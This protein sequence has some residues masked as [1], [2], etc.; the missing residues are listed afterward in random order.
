MDRKTVKLMLL[1]LC[2]LLQLVAGSCVCNQKKETA[3]QNPSLSKQD[4]IQIL[5]ALIHHEEFLEELPECEDHTPFVIVK[6]G[7]IKDTYHIQYKTHP[8]VLQTLTKV[9]YVNGVYEDN[10]IP[11]FPIYRIGP[12][13]ML[14]I[15][16]FRIQPDSVF[17]RIIL[18]GNKLFFDFYFVKDV[19]GKWRATLLDKFQS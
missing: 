10:P 7:Y 8:L 9:L 14:E 18:C 3:N 6:T 17:I 11:E 15:R 19:N 13:V 4:S 12:K 1:S 2:V 5:T 16:K